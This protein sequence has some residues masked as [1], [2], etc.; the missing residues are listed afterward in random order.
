MESEKILDR[1]PHRAV[2]PSVKHKNRGGWTETQ[3]EPK[4]SHTLT[5]GLGEQT[6]YQQGTRT[7]N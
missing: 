3:I 1:A 6:E 4:D 2:E 7:L 5:S